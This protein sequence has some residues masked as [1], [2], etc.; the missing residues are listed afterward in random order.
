[1]ADSLAAHRQLAAPR[2]RD[3]RAGDGDDAAHGRR[4][5]PPECRR[6]ALHADGAGL[7]WPGVP[8]RLRPGVRGHEPAE[9]LHRVRAASSPAGSQGGLR[10][11]LAGVSPAAASCPPPAAALILRPASAA[12]AA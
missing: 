9:R 4:G 6:P 1:M 2:H 11:S 5:G 8:G 10:A 12:P 7:R 3:A